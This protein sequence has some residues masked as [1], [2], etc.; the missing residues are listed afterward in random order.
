MTTEEKK[1]ILTSNGV[2]I[3]SNA[4]DSAIDAEY[5]EFIADPPATYDEGDYDSEEPE[6][7]DEEVEVI[8]EKEPAPLTPAKATDK[9]TSPTS[10]RME[11]YRKFRDENMDRM[12]GSKT[13]VVV[14]WAKENL[15]KEEFDSI[16]GRSNYPGRE[17][18][19]KA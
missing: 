4:S 8:E 12:I 13:P 19:V 2:K 5:D 14:E 18:R 9:K 7:T 1:E 16:Y 11:A 3:R 17:T 15:S 6:L 10:S